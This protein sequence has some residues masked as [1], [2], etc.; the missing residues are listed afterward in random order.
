MNTAKVMMDSLP[1][2]LTPEEIANLEAAEKMPITFDEDRPEMTSD[3]LKQ[4]HRMDNVTIKI[5]PSNMKKIRALG[6][7]PVRVLSRLIDLA[8]D[9]ADLVKSACQLVR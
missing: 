3:M 2:Q 9:D 5:Y 7:D 4:F 8:L 1:A 6:S